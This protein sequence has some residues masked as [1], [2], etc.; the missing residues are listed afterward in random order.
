M[1]DLLR[2]CL[3]IALIILGLATVVPFLFRMAKAG[4]S[5]GMSFSGQVLY[6]S[7]ASCWIIY[8]VA[9]DST[10]LL[11]SGIADAVC[12]VALGVL[13]F[14]YRSWRLSLVQFWPLLIL[15]AALSLVWIFG[16]VVYAVSFAAFS[17]MRWM[18][19]ITESLRFLVSGRC[20]GGV[21]LSGSIIGGVMTLGW[22]I[23][24][25]WPLMGIGTQNE[26]WPSIVWGITGTISFSLQLFLV[27]KRHRTHTPFSSEPAHAG[28]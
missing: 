8:A 11:I 28:H 27:G 14:K 6:L 17:S 4:T 12:A 22:L 9:Y 23:W 13:V 25:A 3:G 26:D 19:Q 24:G 10:I 20:A 18:P 15:A 7:A 21:S 1:S 2:D 16:P 5:D